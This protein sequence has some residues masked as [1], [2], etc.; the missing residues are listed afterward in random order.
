MADQGFAE[1][2]EKPTPKK[3]QDTRKKGEVAKS[4]ELPSVAV[5]MAGVS[6]LAISGTYMS[7]RMRINMEKIFTS[8]TLNDFNA[9]D[10]MALGREVVGSFFLTLA[11]F[12]AAVFLAAIFSN[13]VQV[14]FMV[15]GESIQPK[16]SKLSPIKGFSRL[17]S[18]QSLMEFFKS[19]LKLAIVAGVGYVAI[20]RELDGLSGLAGMEISSITFYI[21]LTTL[22]ICLICA[23]AMVFLVAVDYAFQ[24]WQFE[25]RIMMSKQEIK[26]ELKRS[27]GDP[28]VK[29]R[30]KS[31]Q[32]EMAKKRMMQDVPKADVVITNPTHFAVALSYDNSMNAPTVLAKGAG[33]IAKKIKAIATEHDVP[34]VENKPLARSLYSL[35]DIGSEIPGDLYQGVAEVLAFI[36]K[37]RQ[38]NPVT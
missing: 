16:L 24:K 32:M 25:K 35:V 7:S 27:E 1:K 23:L 31:I 20:T 38:A 29:A 36:Y 8:I 18:M 10:A 11:P 6:A 2:T 19:L 33:E 22:K 26:E 21:L 12:F 9:V 13:I 34:I 37:Q 14:G 28:M 15:T 30:I 17:V 4:R 5:L 3:R